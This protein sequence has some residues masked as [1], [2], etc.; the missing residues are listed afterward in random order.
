MGFKKRY[1]K[2][3]VLLFIF[4][5]FSGNNFYAQV[6]FWLSTD[7][8]YDT[9]PFRFRTAR[10]SWVSVFDFGA[11]YDFGFLS[12][13]YAGSYNT[14]T[15]FSERNF[16]W[17]QFSAS[18]NGEDYGLG[19]NYENRFNTIYFNLYDYSELN[20]YYNQQFFTDFINIFWNSEAALNNYNNLSELNNYSF[21]S[22][23]KLQKS[24]ESRTTIIASVGFVHKNYLNTLLNQTQTTIVLLNALGNG[25]GYGNGPGNMG[26]GHM[27]FG[28]SD[29]MGLQFSELTTRSVGQLDFMLRIA[30]SVF[31]TTGLAFQYYQSF[32]LSG[33][34]RDIYGLSY[35]YTDESQFFDD[36]M[37][38]EQKSIG[39]EL[40]HVLPAFIR[41]KAAFYKTS[42]NYNSQ[43]IYSDATTT[44]SAVLRSDNRTYY[45]FSL[46]RQF[47][48]DLLLAKNIILSLNI[49]KLDN[50]SN[51]Y[52][53]NYSNLYSNINC[54][55]E[56]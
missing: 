30:Q 19:I 6:N 23:V 22:A 8:S 14:F 2:R 46:L 20:A 56:F 34:N 17:Q 41:L 16:Y 13:D 24:F 39:L 43:A 36:P 37:G 11:G 42:K 45:S 47:D 26:R 53:Y 50:S 12:I 35:N 28:S 51:S 54:M 29:S 9:N 3:I 25:V 40:T 55:L 44:D 15:N 27:G 7:Q 18:K 21:F 4:A 33:N 5:V 32:I 38:Y 10:E 31:S 1:F 48:G 52:W 49:Y